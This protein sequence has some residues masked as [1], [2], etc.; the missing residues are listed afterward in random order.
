MNTH[1]E[2]INQLNVYV[3]ENAKFSEKGVKAAAGRARKA[4]N[5]V[6]KLAATR[7]KEI[8]EAKN[9]LSVKKD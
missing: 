6:R 3:E 4:L 8:T 9:A 2:L 5:E 7:R 1:D